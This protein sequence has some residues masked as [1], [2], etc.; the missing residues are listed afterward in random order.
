[1]GAT[2]LSGLSISPINHTAATLA[3]VERNHAGKMITLNRA[4][5]VAVTLPAATG[6]GAGYRFFVGTTFTSD[7]TIKVANASDTMAGQAIID[8]TT[9]TMFQ[10]AATSDTI[11]LNGSTTGGLLGTQI[12]V[13]D[14][15]ANVWYVKVLGNG[16]GT[17]ATPFSATVS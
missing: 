2:H 5:G 7:A 4:G 11:T 14:V 3:I 15:E 17:E 1:M 6:S 9:S 12:E 10:T 13:E 8:G 16:S